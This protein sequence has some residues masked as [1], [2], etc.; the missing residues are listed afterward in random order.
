ME[1]ILHR[2]NTWLFPNALTTENPNDFT[3]RGSSEK[4]LN[5]RQVCEAAVAR[6]GAD[7]SAAAMNHAVELWLK[8]PRTVAFDKILTVQ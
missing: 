3:A 5:V 6:G 8:E 2:I 1:A 4:S 7:V